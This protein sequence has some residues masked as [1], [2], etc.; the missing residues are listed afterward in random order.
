MK[1][2]NIIYCALLITLLL[3]FQF[4]YAQI[5]IN[6]GPEVTPIDMV[7][8]ILGDGVL[9][10]NVTFQGADISRGIFSN[11]DSTNIG[12]DKGVFLTSG[13][14]YKIPGPNSYTSAGVNNGLGGH[15]VFYGPT[16]DAAVL[17]FDVVP[18]SDTLKLTY[19]FGSEEY[20]EWVGS[21]FN[22]VFG[23]FVT[24]P[25]PLGGFYSDK[26]IAI[27][28]GTANTYVAINN[29]N[30]GY[31]PGNV[32]TTGPCN[33]CEYF[34]DNTG[35]LT[36]QYDGFTTVLTA[37]LLV[38]PCEEYHLKLGVADAGDHIYDSG[39]LIAE[40]SITCPK[41]DVEAQLNPPDIINSMIEGFVDADIFIKLPHVD[42]SPLTVY[43]G[44]GG[45]ADPL[46]FPPGDFE[47]AIPTEVSFNVGEDSS[48]FNVK[49]VYDAIIEGEE[50]L[51]LIVENTLGC[52]DRY[53][54]VVFTILDYVEMVSQTSPNVM[55]CEGQ[56]VDLWVEVYNG[57]PPYTYLWEPGGITTNTITVSPEETTTYTV[58]FYDMFM[59]SSADSVMVV[60]FPNNYEI[61]SFSFE[62]ENNPMLFAD[63]TGEIFE[64]SISLDIPI[65]TNLENLV[66]TFNLSDGSW[67]M[68]NGEDQISGITA[69]DFTD[70][71]TYKVIAPGGCMKD[72]VVNVNLVTGQP[73]DTFNNISIFPNPAKEKIYIK[74]AQGNT[75]TIINN[76]GVELFQEQINSSDFTI[77]VSNF[78][79][80]LYFLH[81]KNDQRWFVEK[82]IIN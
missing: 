40:N 29:V 9:Y 81:F 63:V 7:E 22:D 66:A 56:E 6:S 47:E 57:F 59:E 54:T 43:F 72:W 34:I 30:N 25:N 64:D 60:V 62:T 49:P 69:N 82:V 1:S 2:I 4:S 12:I 41:I 77:D 44:V 21:S 8:S 75:L 55:I 19:V 10:S 58:T 78:E 52:I 27:V 16:F 42:Y 45:T 39:V 61:F 38:D 80:G 20:N 11:G 79:E 67:A 14:G 74:H 46:A 5:I 37:W 71:V 28:P 36:I 24:G 32:V 17:E 76:L 15:P 73:E 33:N 65:G 26:N 51:Q 31:A 70:P 35:G 3:T 68:V 18:E 48:S 13:A 50:T 53:D 23:L